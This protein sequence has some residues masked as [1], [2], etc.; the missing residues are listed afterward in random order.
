MIPTLD[1]HPD[2]NGPFL[3]LNSDFTY[4]L[5]ILPMNQRQTV[6]ST[7]KNQNQPPNKKG[8]DF[9]M[10]FLKII[11]NVYLNSCTLQISVNIYYKHAAKITNKGIKLRAK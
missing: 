8:S 6:L 5:D 11:S 2:Y 3:V 9:H 10:M 1:R 4:S 7:L